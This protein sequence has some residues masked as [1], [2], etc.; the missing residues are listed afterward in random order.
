MSH[1]NKQHEHSEP[2]PDQ[3]DEMLQQMS[4]LAV[5]IEAA[6]GFERAM[7]ITHMTR[8]DPEKVEEMRRFVPTSRGGDDD[9]AEKEEFWREM[10]QETTGS[11]EGRRVLHEM[12]EQFNEM[13]IQQA[14]QAAEKPDEPEQR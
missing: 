9:S 2:T 6:G 1:R 14:E 11:L 7:R 5:T 13:E 3:A 8:D 4:M 12:R 10:L